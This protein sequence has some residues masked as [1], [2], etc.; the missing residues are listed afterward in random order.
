MGGRK[1]NGK[2]GNYIIISKIY[3]NHLNTV[4]LSEIIIR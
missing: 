4:K 1:V 3:R 2:L